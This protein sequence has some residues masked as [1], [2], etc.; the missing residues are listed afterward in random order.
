M[1]VSEIVRRCALRSARLKNPLAGMT[2]YLNGLDASTPTL[3]GKQLPPPMNTV[4]LALP[5]SLPG[6]ADG[7]ALPHPGR[8]LRGAEILVVEDDSCIAQLL[9]YMLQREGFSVRHLADGEVAHRHVRTAAPP[10]LVL[11]DSMLP[12]RDGLSLVADM[13]RDA[14]WSRVPVV[15]LTARSLESD[16]VEA[17]DCGVAD[18]IVKPFQPREVLARLRRVLSGHRA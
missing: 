4:P 13:R 1:E 11:L 9:V 12:Y 6:L 8:H 14:R 18:Y 17:L 15:M 7:G 5:S 16:I 2:A 10:A 3:Q